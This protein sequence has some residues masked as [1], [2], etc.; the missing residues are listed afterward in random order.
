ML[1]PLRRIWSSFVTR[2]PSGVD[3]N[4]V[5]SS[6]TIFTKSS[7][8]LSVPTISLSFFMI[9]WRRLPIALSTSSKYLY[10]NRG[11]IN[12]IIVDR[13]ISP[14]PPK[15]KHPYNLFISPYRFCMRI[16]NNKIFNVNLRRARYFYLQEGYFI[17]NVE[18]WINTSD[19]LP[20]GRSVDWLLVE[21]VVDA[22]MSWFKIYLIHFYL[23]TFFAFGITSW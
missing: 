4:S 15:L 13:N 18:N 3:S 2:F 9:M 5:T 10:D 12:S 19:S 22:M 23:Y 1:F 14:C 21:D 16:F 6:K 8:P 17:C 7:N 20:R 11:K